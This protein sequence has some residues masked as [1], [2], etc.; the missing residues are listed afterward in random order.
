MVSGQ[1]LQK[2]AN[3]FAGELRHIKRL[4][5]WSLY[6]VLIEKYEWPKK[7]ARDFADFL[8]PMLEFDPNKRATAAMCLRHPWLTSP[9]DEE[10]EGEEDD[11]DNIEDED[12]AVVI[13]SDMPDAQVVVQHE[14]IEAD[15]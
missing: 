10:D 11:E 3:C 8:V 15:S 12:A 13:T 7:K 14:E 6:D 2:Y 1:K 5:P 9:C 4:K